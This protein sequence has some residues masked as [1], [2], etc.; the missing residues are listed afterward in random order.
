MKFEGIRSISMGGVFLQVLREVDDHDSVKGAFLHKSQSINK[1]CPLYKHTSH[2]A[3]SAPCLSTLLSLP[4][5]DTVTD[6]LCHV[7]VTKQ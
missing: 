4:N 3:A 6:R 5:N 7:T 1:N 2:S